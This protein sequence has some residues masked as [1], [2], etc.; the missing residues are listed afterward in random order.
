MQVWEVGTSEHQQGWLTTMRENVS[1]LT[2]KS[3]FTSMRTHVSEDGRRVAVYAQWR[4]RASF[5]A[6]IATPEAKAG[7]EALCA[8]GMPDGNVY[9]VAEV[10]LPD[11]SEALFEDVSR[12]WAELGLKS[13]MIGVNGVDLHVASG[14]TGSPL[15]LP[16]GYPQSG[17]IWRSVVP[18]LTKTHHVIVPDL[19]GMGLSGIARSGYDLP[20]VA[21][22]L[23]QLI[24]HV[25][26]R[27]AAVA[28]HDWGGAVGAVWALRHR[29]DV[30]N[31]PS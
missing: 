22:D 31:S 15:V 23:H 30:T 6:G 17:E 9:K 19:R 18:E 5:E 16:H 29:G 28:G 25:G 7:H 13:S 27:Q 3:G 24:S 21:D 2:G 10:F 12:R 20:N 26:L 8:H 4:D 14:G 1:A 11:R